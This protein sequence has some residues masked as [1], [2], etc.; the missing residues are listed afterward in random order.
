MAQY[1]NAGSVLL[2]TGEH[3]AGYASLHVASCKQTPARID[4]SSYALKKKRKLSFISLM[5]GENMIETT[6]RLA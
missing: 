4:I 1:F 5:R 6:D 3:K 2:T